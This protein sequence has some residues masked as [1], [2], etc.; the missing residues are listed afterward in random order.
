MD[1]YLSFNIDY[2]K[3]SNEQTIINYSTKKFFKIEQKKILNNWF[4]NNLN[5][6]YLKNSDLINLSKETG[7]TN[8]QI[9]T[10]FINKRIRSKK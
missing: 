5:N 1:Y 6:P 9:R 3:E 10:Y 7:L 2:Q 8:K 4:E